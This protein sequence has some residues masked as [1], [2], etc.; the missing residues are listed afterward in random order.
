MP[1]L[2]LKTRFLQATERLH[3]YQKYYWSAPSIFISLLSCLNL[4][5]T[6][7][8]SATFIILVPLSSGT[9]SETFRRSHILFFVA[10]FSSNC[11]PR[12]SIT[13]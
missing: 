12:K 10:C 8:Y 6:K 2:S 4:V 11:R 3:T 1:S 7:F 13:V 9:H 5:T